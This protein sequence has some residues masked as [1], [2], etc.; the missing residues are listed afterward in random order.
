MR[1]ILTTHPSA[2]KVST[3][4]VVVIAVIDPEMVQKVA[5]VEWVGHSD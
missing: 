4:M 2:T 5:M 1:V 3:K